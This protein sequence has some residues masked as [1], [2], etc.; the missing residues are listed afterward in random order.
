MLSVEFLQGLRKMRALQ[1]L[2]I[3]SCYTKGSG[4][5]SYLSDFDY[6]ELTAAGERGD[7]QQGALSGSIKARDY[8]VH[9]HSAASIISFTRAAASEIS[10]GLTCKNIGVGE[11]LSWLH[12]ACT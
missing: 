8:E 12:W 3:D 1:K 2:S 11:T 10:A 5:T 4:C 7:D 9:V 6:Q